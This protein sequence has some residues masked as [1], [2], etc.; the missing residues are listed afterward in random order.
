M[1]ISLATIIQQ[2]ASSKHKAITENLMCI[3]KT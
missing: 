1:P 3:G 2:L